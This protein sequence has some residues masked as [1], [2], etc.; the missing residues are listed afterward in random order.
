MAEALTTGGQF[1]VR[2]LAIIVAVGVFT[3]SLGVAEQGI[4]TV[5][6]CP[7]SCDSERL[8]RSACRDWRE[9]DRC[10]VERLVPT[11][12]QRYQLCVN[13]R[14]ATVRLRTR[15]RVAAGERSIDLNTLRG[16]AG[17]AGP[18]GAPGVN[19]A[20]GSDSAPGVNGTD[21]QDGAPGPNGLNGQNGV[22]G[23]DGADGVL[24][25]YGDGSR[26][27]RQVT[28]SGTLDDSNPQYVDFSVA[29][30]V[31]LAVHSG[32]VIRCTGTFR[33]EG[34]IEVLPSLRDHPRF[35][36]SG[37]SNKTIGSG[38]QEVTG[39]PGGAGLG[40]GIAK[41]LLRL[42]LSGGGN[43]YRQD[44]ESGG[45]GGGTFTVLCRG[46]VENL[47]TIRANGGD[48]TVLARG[49][50]GGGFVVLASPTSVENDG[51]IEGQ[52]GSGSGLLSTAPNDQGQGPGG[53]GGGGIVHLISPVILGVGTVDLFGGA[54][55]NAGSSGS[56]TG[57]LYLG[58][59][60]GGGSG[61]AGGAGGTVNPSP[62][63]DNSTG[64][65]ATGASGQLIQT[66]ADPA[67]LF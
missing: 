16:E 1:F 5:R 52:G 63:S 51:L 18:Q 50:G 39:G 30:G 60:G 64:A 20:D 44:G 61:G 46:A 29:S 66:N 58:G 17:P 22:D 45:D 37:Q 23:A 34:I 2:F 33:N 54:G 8:T 43:G 12:P 24:R 38:G 11:Q 9:G 35:A 40:S 4:V 25:I 6:P 53:G 62:L 36:E 19:G 28:S 21:G 59:G 48:A 3:P 27:S 49:G 55:G 56:I 41:G 32:T 13:Q 42:G 15:C 67:S 10:F 31:T 7:Y 47:G 14:S 26:G 65:G 57:M